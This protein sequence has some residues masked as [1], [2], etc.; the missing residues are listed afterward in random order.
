MDARPLIVF[1][2]IYSMR[3]STLYQVKEPS[4]FLTGPGGQPYLYRLH[5]LLL[6]MRSLLAS[7]P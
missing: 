5:P 3:D 4:W 2:G 7:L 6:F 1:Q